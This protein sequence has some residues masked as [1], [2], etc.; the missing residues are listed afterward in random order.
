MFSINRRHFL[1]NPL[2]ISCQPRS[3]VIPILR[4]TGSVCRTQCS[5]PACPKPGV[6]SSTSNTSC[7]SMSSAGGAVASFK[8]SPSNFTVLSRMSLDTIPINPLS[9]TSPQ[10]PVLKFKPFPFSFARSG[11]VSYKG[12]FCSRVYPVSHYSSW[13]PPPPTPLPYY[14]PWVAGTA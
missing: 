2:W 12:R 13:S 3:E 11:L 14:S 7:S 5:F 9:V 1:Y 6:G 4:V 8:E 10:L